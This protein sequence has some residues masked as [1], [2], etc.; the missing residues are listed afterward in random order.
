MSLGDKIS[1]KAVDTQAL[2]GHIY[3]LV[4]TKDDICVPKLFLFGHDC[5]SE[6]ESEQPL[7]SLSVA[8]TLF[9]LA[10]GSIHKIRPC[11][12]TTSQYLIKFIFVCPCQMMLD[13]NCSCYV[14]GIFI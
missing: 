10:H 4:G 7:K 13:T 3:S 6:S 11:A 14:V 8:G 9:T 2:H 5:A 1:S 12:K